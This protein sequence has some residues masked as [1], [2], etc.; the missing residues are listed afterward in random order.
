M[1]GMLNIIDDPYNLVEEPTRFPYSLNKKD[2]GEVFIDRVTGQK[3]GMFVF[4]K[5]IYGTEEHENEK[6]V[7]RSRLLVKTRRQFR[8][9]LDSYKTWYKNYIVEQI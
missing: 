6:S 5:D 9:W 8:A 3:I 2:F 4:K 7:Y 1:I